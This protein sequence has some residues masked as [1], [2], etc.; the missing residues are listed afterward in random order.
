MMY[1]MCIIIYICM[2]D[3]ALLFF[4]FGRVYKY[5]LKSFLVFGKG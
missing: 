3:D 4:G 5:V 2:L 1:V